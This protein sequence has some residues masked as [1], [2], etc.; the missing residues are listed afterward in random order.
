MGEAMAPSFVGPVPY[1]IRHGGRVCIVKL[2]VAK[3]SLTQVP[4]NKAL[5]TKLWG[6]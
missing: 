4:G 5:V 6:A 2:G 3:L 1:W